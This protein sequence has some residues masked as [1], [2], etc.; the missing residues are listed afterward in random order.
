MLGTSLGVLG[1]LE[2]VTDGGNL[3]AGSSVV[4]L[5][6]HIAD[7]TQAQSLGSGLVLGQT[8]VQA[9]LTS[10][11]FSLAISSPP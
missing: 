2:Q 3:A 9:L 1:D 10:L 4:G 11:I 6:G 8:A 7:V 5:H